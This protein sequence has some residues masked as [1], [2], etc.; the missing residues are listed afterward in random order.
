MV[1]L[2][3]QA[4]EAYSAAVTLCSTVTNR[5]EEAAG[6]APATAG[7]QAGFGDAL[8]PSLRSCEAELLRRLHSCRDRLRA[9]VVARIDAHLAEC[10]WP[11]PLVAAGGGSEAP[12]AAA[13]P[14]PKAAAAAAAASAPPA[15][16]AQF[17]DP[18]RATAVAAL[19]RLMIALMRLQRADQ[20]AAFDALERPGQPLAAMAGDGAPLLWVAQQLAAPLER[21][22]R[23]HFG[24]GA[25]AGRLDRPEWMLRTVLRLTQ[26]LGPQLDFL[27]VGGW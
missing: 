23:R 5:E 7:S 2:S 10:S 19:Q 25:A 22:L 13:S 24:N 14:N 17:S 11:P 26:E 4:A 20:K 9:A 3:T 27:Q 12:G 8:P 15:S 18:D 1:R 21:E 16:P 6:S